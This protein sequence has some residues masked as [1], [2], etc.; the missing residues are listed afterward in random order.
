[1]NS[2]DDEELSFSEDAEKELES[3]VWFIVSVMLAVAF[4]ITVL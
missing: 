4:Y 2:I 3:I 1:M